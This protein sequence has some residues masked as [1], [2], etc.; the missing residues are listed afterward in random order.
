M[1][2]IN[3]SPKYCFSLRLKWEDT[4]SKSS[5][6]NSLGCGERDHV[7]VCNWNWHMR[8]LLALHTCVS[9]GSFFLEKKTWLY[10]LWQVGRA[11]VNERAGSL[12]S[13]WDVLKDIPEPAAL[14][15][16]CQGDAPGIVSP[17][18]SVEV[19]RDSG[20][21]QHTVFPS[22]H[23]TNTTVTT[24]QL[25]TWDSSTQGVAWRCH[26]HNSS[27]N[28]SLIPLQWAVIIGRVSTEPGEKMPN[29]FTQLV[30]YNQSEQR[31]MWP[32]PADKLN[33]YRIP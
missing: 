3:V 22:P 2:S 31:S 4:K 27:Q 9:P 21:S 20:Y 12:E 29:W 17:L 26:T 1:S 28:M 23:T 5:R 6:A 16:G 15:S 19:R 14:V 13:S 7:E 8:T 24:S 25:Q 18:S 11:H 33:F 10:L 32:G 30:T